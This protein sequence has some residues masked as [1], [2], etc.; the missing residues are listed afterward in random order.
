ML[1]WC[2]WNNN[3]QPPN[4]V[5]KQNFNLWE[6]GMLGSMFIISSRVV[7]IMLIVFLL[8]RGGRDPARDIL[9]C[10]VR[11]SECGFILAQT[12]WKFAKMSTIER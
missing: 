1:L 3:R 12:I 5:G 10:C 4:Q 9:W 7:V 2:I 6:P 8:E 11:K